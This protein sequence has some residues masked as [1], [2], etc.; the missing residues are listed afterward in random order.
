[1]QGGGKMARKI[2]SGEVQRFKNLSQNDIESLSRTQAQD[3]LRSMR[4]AFQQREKTLGRDRIDSE[5]NRMGTWSPAAESMEKFYE[6]REIKSPSRTRKDSAVAELKRL[7]NFFNAKT[8]TVR[9]AREVMRQQDLR[10]FGEKE[11][12]FGKPTGQPAQRLT[13]QQRDFMWSGYQEF[14]SGSD[15][16]AIAAR[17]YEKRQQAAGLVVKSMRGKKLSIEDFMER[18]KKVLT[19]MEDIESGVEVEDVDPIA[20]LLS[21][22]GDDFY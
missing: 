22:T 3:L 9:G 11:N 10:I 13:R 12:A 20:E 5:G 7:N 19:Q 16:A 8:S 17:S 14:L 21:G 18:L 6:N 15:T 1:M 4:Q 2:S